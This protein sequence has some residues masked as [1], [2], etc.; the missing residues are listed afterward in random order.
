MDARTVPPQTSDEIYKKVVAYVKKVFES[1]K[2][3]S[4]LENIEI[5]ASGDPWIT[6]DTDWV[7]QAADAATLVSQ[8]VRCK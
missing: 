4:I 5:T 6:D 2:T 7:Y 1:L 3:K 8:N